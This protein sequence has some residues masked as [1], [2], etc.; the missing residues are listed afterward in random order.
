MLMEDQKCLNVAKHHL[1][2]VLNSFLKA[3]I[4][5]QL[6]RNNRNGVGVAKS[7]LSYR[8]VALL[9]RMRERNVLD[10][11]LICEHHCNSVISALIHVGEMEFQGPVVWDHS[12]M[13]MAVNLQC[14][15]L[16]T[17]VEEKQM[18]LTEFGICASCCRLPH[19]HTF[20]QANAPKARRNEK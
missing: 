1:S 2:K 9:L 10:L 13:M 11:L 16:S 19:N 6:D 4:R 12:I 5:S 8:F 20:L 17:I 7:T 18:I 15:T 14:V 3:L